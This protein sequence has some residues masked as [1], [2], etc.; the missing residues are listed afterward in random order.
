MTCEGIGGRSTHFEG[1][2]MS[3]RPPHLHI[4]PARD[5]GSSAQQR[6]HNLRLSSPGQL[7]QRKTAREN[8]DDKKRHTSTKRL[9]A[10][11]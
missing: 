7:T 11:G 5:F 3:K 9:L 8:K 6:G 10:V 2:R 1:R 4:A